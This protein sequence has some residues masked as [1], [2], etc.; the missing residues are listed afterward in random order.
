MNDKNGG[1]SS[2]QQQYRDNEPQVDCFGH[3]QGT[4]DSETD[5]EQIDT[6]VT[7]K[8]DE[9]D[10]S[11]HY[12][13]VW[14]R[15][16]KPSGFFVREGALGTGDEAFTEQLSVRSTPMSC[17]YTKRSGNHENDSDEQRK[18]GGF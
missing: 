6:D 17:Q 13:T 9:I 7:T 12:V 15:G 4:D 8:R 3:P 10:L 14:E 2:S 5:A 1:E 11:K 16:S 18:R